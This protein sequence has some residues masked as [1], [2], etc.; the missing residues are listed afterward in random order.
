MAVLGERSLEKTP[1][2]RLPGKY[3]DLE[4]APRKSWLL[5]HHRDQDKTPK[6][7]GLLKAR[8]YEFTAPARQLLVI[9]PQAKNKFQRSI[10]SDF[11]L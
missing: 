8:S 5:G 3:S 9:M 10:V 6:R 1:S 4:N 2:R 11:S 7:A